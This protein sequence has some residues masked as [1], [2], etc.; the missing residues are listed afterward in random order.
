MYFVKEVIIQRLKIKHKIKIS[1]IVANK[2]LN[3]SLCENKVK[4]CKALVL[5]YVKEKINDKR[6]VKVKYLAIFMILGIF[7][8]NR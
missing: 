8:Q 1:K 2:V 3:A 5:E 6:R 7:K 4:L